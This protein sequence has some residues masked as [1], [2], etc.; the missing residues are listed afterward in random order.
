MVTDPDPDWQAQNADTDPATLCQSDRIRIK[1]PLLSSKVF[2]FWLTCLQ[3]I[4]KRR[5]LY[6]LPSRYAG[7]KAGKE[8]E[9]H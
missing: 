2:M 5:H 7:V 4:L 6:R 1:Q 8:K 9:K 3:Q